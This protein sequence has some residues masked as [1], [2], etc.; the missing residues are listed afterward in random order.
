M[1]AKLLSTGILFANSDRTMALSIL[2]RMHCQR[3]TFTIRRSFHTVTLWTTDSH[4][5]CK[6]PCIAAQSLVPKEM[7]IA[8]FYGIVRLGHCLK[9]RAPRGTRRGVF[10]NSCRRRNAGRHHEARPSTFA[11]ALGRDDAVG[12]GR[13][14]RADPEVSRACEARNDVG[15]C[16]IHDGDDQG[17][18]SEGPG[19]MSGAHPRIAVAQ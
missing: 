18:L 5:F 3:L 4:Q 7:G 9:P 17:Q 11:A 6:L 16:G 2:P 19:T 15:L 13:A 12:T 8:P 10:S 14:P 1:C